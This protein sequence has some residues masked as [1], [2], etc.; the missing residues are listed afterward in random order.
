MIIFIIAIIILIIIMFL[1][2]GWSH[3]LCESNNESRI[4][5]TH[6][7]WMF[8]WIDLM[9]LL[10]SLFCVEAVP[11]NLYEQHAY[12]EHP[13]PPHCA[14]SFLTVRGTLQQTLYRPRIV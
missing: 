11:F 10:S 1:F 12:R 7:V 8:F 13:P 9:P 3:L 4:E 2:L 5:V 6:I 14:K